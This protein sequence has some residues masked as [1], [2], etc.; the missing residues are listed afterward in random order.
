VIP[1]EE[2]AATA[3]DERHLALLEAVGIRS[4]IV[5]PLRTGASILGTLSLVSSSASRPF[6]DADLAF[7]EELGRRAAVALEHA[8]LYGERSHIAATLQHSLVPADP[9]ELPGW[10]IAALYRPAGDGI[11]AGGDFYDIV[12]TERGWMTFVGDV[13]GKGAEA[14]ALTALCRYTLRSAAK[15][16][17]DAGEA[18][19]HL[20]Q[21]LVDADGLLLCTAVALQFD[22]SGDCVLANAGHPRALLVQNG[23]PISRER[24]G[25]LLGI[26]NDDR[27]PQ[28]R[29]VLSEH[30][31][32]VLYTDGVLDGVGESGERFGEARVAAALT[33]VASAD[34]RLAALVGEIEAF[35]VG[36]QR[37]DAAALVIERTSVRSQVAAA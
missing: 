15:L 2:L 32:L 27:W 1:E 29:L 13:C 31:T 30:D 28:E 33:G 3:V 26:A 35:Q 16:G 5:V 11:E 7:A 21:A 24:A 12:R 19:A 8:R 10:R 4:A 25:P 14:A 20:N 9:P 18:L 6:D 17:L 22:A 23:R 34:D 36:D 37:D